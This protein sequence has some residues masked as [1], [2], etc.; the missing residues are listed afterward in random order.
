MITPIAAVKAGFRNYAAFSGRATRAEY[1]WWMLFITVG[2]PVSDLVLFA[3]TASFGRPAGLTEFAFLFTPLFA[4]A[5]LLPTFAVTS[6]RLH[7]IGKSG[8]WQLAWH[9]AWA[10][11]WMIAALVFLIA[12]IAYNVYLPPFLPAAAVTFL[13]ALAVTL[14]V[15]IWAIIWLAKPGQPGANDFGPDPGGVNAAAATFPQ[16]N[17]RAADSNR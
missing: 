1:W 2:G 6:R 10:L 12:F 7:D 8:W 13:P 15:G 9:T 3:L 5:T 14:C 11:T 4:L 17:D 16:R